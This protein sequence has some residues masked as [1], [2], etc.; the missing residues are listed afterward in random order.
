MGGCTHTHMTHARPKS[1]ADIRISR[2]RGAPSFASVCEQRLPPR[3]AEPC[4]FPLL[5]PLFD[6][7]AAEAILKTRDLQSYLNT[8]I[9]RNRVYIQFRRLLRF[10]HRTCDPPS[11]WPVRGRGPTGQGV[12]GTGQSRARRVGRGGGHLGRPGGGGRRPGGRPVAVGS[13]TLRAVCSARLWFSF[14]HFQ[15]H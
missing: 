6:D 11:K 10:S 14:S 4:V 9:L 8:R 15:F 5:K 7:I 2:G 13:R 3:P 12:P 1:D